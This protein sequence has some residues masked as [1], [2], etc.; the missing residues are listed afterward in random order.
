[1]LRKVLH[2]ESL[3]GQGCNKSRV[4]FIVIAI[5]LVFHS[6]GN[7]FGDTGSLK[8]S[9]TN[10]NISNLRLIFASGDFCDMSRMVGSVQNTLHFEDEDTGSLKLSETNVNNGRCS[11]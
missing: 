6:T 9:E 8:L 11:K 3:A 1:M 4:K 7:F 5:I 10:V 2:T